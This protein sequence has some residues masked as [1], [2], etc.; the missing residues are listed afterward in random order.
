MKTLIINVLKKVKLYNPVQRF[1]LSIIQNRS[2]YQSNA[3]K[4]YGQFIQNG[5]LCFDIG[6]NVG[7]RAKIFRRLGAKVI[8]LEPQKECLKVL[9]STFKNDNNVKIIGS[10]VGEKVGTA[11][12]TMSIHNDLIASLSDKYVK[13]SRFSGDFDDSKTQEVSVTTLDDLIS[14]YGKPKFCKIDVEGFELEVLKGLSQ[15]LHYVSLEFAKEFLDDT[16]KCLSILSSLGA[17]RFTYS[18]GDSLALFSANWH[19]SSEALMQKMRKHQ[20]DDFWGDVYI[21]FD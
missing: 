4:F 5:D 20:N 15:P 2:E 3:D 17:K 21:S 7:A 9:N 13:E 19:S 1:A 11:Q 16:Q 8:C 12:L 14:K 6:A 18:E 10:A